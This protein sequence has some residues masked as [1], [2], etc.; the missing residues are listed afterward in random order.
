MFLNDN[1]YNKKFVDFRLPDHMSLE[2]GALLEP[3]SVAVHACK[4]A[5]VTL[6]SKVLICGAGPIGLVNLLTAKAMGADQ[7]CLTGCHKPDKSNHR[8]VLC[9]LMVSIGIV[10]TS[11]KVDWKLQRRWERHSPFSSTAKTRERSQRR[12][13][14]RSDSRLTSRSNAVAPNPAFKRQYM[15]V[16]S[17]SISN[18]SV[19][20]HSSFWWGIAFRR[21]REAVKWRQSVEGRE[22]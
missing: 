18:S 15:Y 14:K 1:Q 17:P 2:E 4:R 22:Q 16:T 12:S 20:W 3:L 9:I 11:A 6:G 19:S 7:V 10:Q 5:G 8:N 13:P 21:L